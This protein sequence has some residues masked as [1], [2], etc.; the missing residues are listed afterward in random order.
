MDERMDTMM[1]QAQQEADYQTRV[2]RLMSVGVDTVAEVKA[3]QL[4]R[5]IG[6]LHGQFVWIV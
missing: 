5:A 1:A 3:V 2:A 4:V 6:S